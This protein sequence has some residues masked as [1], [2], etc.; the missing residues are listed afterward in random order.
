[1]ST[2]RFLNKTSMSN[3]RFIF[4]FGRL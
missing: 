2:L 3:F 1:M 4:R